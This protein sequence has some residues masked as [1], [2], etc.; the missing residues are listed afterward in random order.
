M[1]PL[2]KKTH[3]VY[4]SP[5]RKYLTLNHALSVDDYQI[6]YQCAHWTHKYKW[7]INWSNSI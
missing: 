6:P 1:K 4:R 2:T 7:F 5:G 3:L